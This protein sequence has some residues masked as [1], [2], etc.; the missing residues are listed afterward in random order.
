MCCDPVSPSVWD[1]TSVQDPACHLTRLTSG[2]AAEAS[3][4]GGWPDLQDLELDTALEQH[5][6]AQLQ[7]QLAEER[8]RQDEHE[9]VGSV[10]LMLP[11]CA[12][13]R[14]AKLTTWPWPSCCALPAGRVAG[15]AGLIRPPCS[16]RPAW[17]RCRPS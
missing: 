14:P 13:C 17:L 4:N 9:Q 15:Q 3:E 2:C 7:Q 11:V 6:P 1:I 12:C 8:M 16:Q 10:L 5:L